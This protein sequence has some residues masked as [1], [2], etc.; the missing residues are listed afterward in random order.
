MNR[1]ARLRIKSYLLN[2]DRDIFADGKVDFFN[3][4]AVDLLERLGNLTP[5]QTEI[6]LVEKL[7]RNILTVKI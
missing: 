5:S 4:H 7:L 6:D 2:I 3:Y 1:T